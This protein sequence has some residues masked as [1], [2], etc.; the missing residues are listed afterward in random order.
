M[1]FRDFDPGTLGQG[2]RLLTVMVCYSV[3]LKSKIKA[4]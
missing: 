3:I 4:P 1:G 2:F